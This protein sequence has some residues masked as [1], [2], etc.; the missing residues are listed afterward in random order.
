[1]PITAKRAY[2]KIAVVLISLSVLLT[3][4]ASALAAETV[5]NKYNIHIQ[6]QTKRNGDVVY[7]ASYANYTNPGTGHMIVKAG[8][9]ITIT[10]KKRKGCTFTTTDCKAVTFEFHEPRMQMSIDEYLEKITSPKAAST[11][12]LSRLDRQGVDAGKAKVGMSRQ[13][14]MTALGYPAAHKTPSLKDN[15]WT[16]WQDRFRTMVVEFKGDKVVNIRQ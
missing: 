8:S 9:K 13:G 7:K 15:A 12:N 10:Q 2:G 3:L 5:Y 14:V 1:M 4:S 11:K 16:Y 6:Q